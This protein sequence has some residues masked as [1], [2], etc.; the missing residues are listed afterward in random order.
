MQLQCSVQDWS[1]CFAVFVSHMRIVNTLRCQACRITFPQTLGMYAFNIKPSPKDLILGPHRV[2]LESN[3]MFQ[4]FGTQRGR[5]RH[6]SPSQA[7]TTPTPA[8]HTIEE[9]MQALASTLLA[10]MFDPS[11]KIE[12]KQRVRI[13]LIEEPYPQPP[14]GFHPAGEL[15]GLTG[16]TAQLQA[17]MAKCSSLQA[18]DLRPVQAGSSLGTDLEVGEPAC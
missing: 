11:P 6:V 16:P 15:I 3:N 7:L 13:F 2:T 8:Y 10:L 4:L 5:V 18:C 12:S 1:C 17:S 14:Y 9:Q